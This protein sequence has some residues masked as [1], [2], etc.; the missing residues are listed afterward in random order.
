[1]TGFD[2]VL[3]TS[4]RDHGRRVS[5]NAATGFDSSDTA[6]PSRGAGRVVAGTYPSSLYT[7]RMCTSDSR[8][9]SGSTKL[10]LADLPHSNSAEVML[11]YPLVS[12]SGFEAGRDV[13]P[14]SLIVIGS[15]LSTTEFIHVMIWSFAFTAGSPLTPNAWT[16]LLV[17]GSVVRVTP[18]MSLFS[19]NLTQLGN[20]RIVRTSA[21][22]AGVLLPIR[23]DMTTDFGIAATTSEST[24]L[25]FWEIANKSELPG[26]T[27]VSPFSLRNSD[28]QSYC[29]ARN[30]AVSMCISACVVGDPVIIPPSIA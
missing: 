19:T 3:V 26:K 6:C 11:E 2:S 16:S 1:M 23:L 13:S 7:S 28:N 9:A 15:T 4:T 29:S 8:I 27:S 22:V 20:M 24:S 14:V 30:A 21:V 10:P 17:N 25:I 12:H 5:K 18:G